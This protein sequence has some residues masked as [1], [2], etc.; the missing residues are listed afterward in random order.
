MD[1]LGHFET[2]CFGTIRKTFRR[3]WCILTVFLVISDG[4]TNGR[5]DGQT[6]FQRCLDASKKQERKKT[7][8]TDRLE[9]ATYKMRKLV[10]ELNERRTNAKKSESERKFEVI[11]EKTVEDTTSESLSNLANHHQISFLVRKK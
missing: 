8:C 7:R 1:N 11:E 4:R 2:F 6:L 9:L 3:V 5:T 10:C